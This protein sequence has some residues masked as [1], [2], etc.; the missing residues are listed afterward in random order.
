MKLKNLLEQ[1]VDIKKY[2]PPVG[3]S[4]LTPLQV[5]IYKNPTSREFKELYLTKSDVIRC[6]IKSNND[7]FTTNQQ[8]ELI[9]NDILRL[10]DLKQGVGQW[11]KSEKFLKDFICVYRTYDGKYSLSTMYSEECK[12]KFYKKYN[13]YY[14]VKI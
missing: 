13:Q 4:K 8:N 10:I 3:Y 11:H 1:F 2:I 6:V 14:E 5:E 7:I 9:H 12:N